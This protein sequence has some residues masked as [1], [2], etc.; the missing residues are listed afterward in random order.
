MADGFTIDE[1]SFGFTIDE[2]SFG[3]LPQ[4]IQALGER[5]ANLDPILKRRAALL[6]SV[7]DESF[8]T[9]RSPNGAG[10]QALAESTVEKRRQGSSKP[11]LDTGA[12]RQASNAQVRSKAIVFGT[13][14]A[15]AK[16]GVFH[17]TGTSTMPRRAYLPMDEDGNPD[18]SSGPAAAWLEK[19][20]ADVIA[21]V[22]HGTRP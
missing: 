8:R 2:K 15:P 14:G 21:Y 4:R 20:R 16:Y 10:W 22:I 18:F 1:K 17:V 3:T 5:L 19:T 13:S 11:L 7:I 6:G 9:S 12:L